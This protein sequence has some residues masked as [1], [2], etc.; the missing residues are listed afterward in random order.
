MTPRK[1][2]WKSTQIQEVLLEF[3]DGL[4]ATPKPADEGPVFLG[5][6]NITEDG[7]LDL[8]GVRHI[9]EEDFSHW[10]KRVEPRPGDIVF[11]YEATLNLRLQNQRRH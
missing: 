11:S 6:R 7:H 2:A 4:H 5:I 10:T 1:Q 8:S 3:Y 9:A